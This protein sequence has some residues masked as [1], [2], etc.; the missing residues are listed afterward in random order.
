MDRHGPILEALKDCQVV[1]SHGMGRRIHEDLRSAGIEA[2]ITDET[3]VDEALSFYLKGEL[4]DR[5]ERLD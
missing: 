2:F 3:S 4:E 1:I 5:I